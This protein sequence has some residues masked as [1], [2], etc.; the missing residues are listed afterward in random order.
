MATKPGVWAR[1]NL[2]RPGGIAGLILLAGGVAVTAVNWP[3]HWSYD[4]VVQLDQGRSGLYNAWHPPVMAWLLGLADR[5]QRGGALFTVLEAALVFG[6]LA[7]LAALAGRRAWAAPAAALAALATPQLAIYPA[8]VWK[9]VLFAGAA[10]SAFVCL[11]WAGRV[12][13][14]RA[15]RWALIAKAAALLGLAA[16]A[17]QN[18]L[19]LIP[20]AGVTLAW[21][22]LRAEDAGRGAGRR[23]RAFGTGLV[24]ALAAALIAM[25]GASALKLHSDG[26]NERRRQWEE[27]RIYEM[28]AARSMRPELSF[29]I[30]AAEAP[31]MNDFLVTRGPALLKF[32]RIDPLVQNPFI[33]AHEDHDRP[34]VLAQWRA[35]F[36]ADPMLYLRV[37]ARLFAW[38]FLTPD[39]K[40]C[41]PLSVGVDGPPQLMAG[42]GL[43]ER[44][45][46]RDD[47]VFSYAQAFFGTPVYR[48][49]AWAALAA[50][51]MIACLI[52]RRPEDVAVAGLTASA[53][54]FAGT[55]FLISIACDYRYL[56]VLDLAA[57]AGALYG[58]ATFGPRQGPKT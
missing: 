15:W 52:R 6:S 24:L 23:W 33:N 27:L 3:G 55:F 13:P 35:I 38:V 8:I 47:A 12:W 57:L 56:Y 58:A 21:I 32:Q 39:L 29:P 34:A 5:V 17:R 40:A 37:R 10:V 7:A 28:A 43:G 44:Y 9:D 36:A 50:A 2:S 53:L 4:S 45:S 18:G 51:V 30:L 48:H 31:A 46:D 42:L 22:G 41:V 49:A 16:L 14:A 19:V 20:A 1:L 26:Q 11:A 25:A 54:G